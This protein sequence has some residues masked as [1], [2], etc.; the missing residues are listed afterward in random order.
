MTLVSAHVP[1]TYRALVDIPAIVVDSMPMT[2]PIITRDITQLNTPY[3]SSP[4]KSPG[5]L[6][7]DVAFT[8]DSPADSGID[9]RR[10]SRRLS[11]LSMRSGDITYQHK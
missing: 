10:Q 2:P 3:L 4:S 11:D 7:H 1:P 8:L 9:S 6:T 5:S